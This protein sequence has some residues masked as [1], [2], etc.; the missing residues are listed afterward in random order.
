MLQK[1]AH[2]VSQKENTPIKDIFNHW[3]N[4]QPV[5]GLINPKEIALFV[6][7]MLSYELDGLTGASL[8]FDGGLTAA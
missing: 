2:E 6:K 8:N 4:S 3:E 1:T 5:C 7:L